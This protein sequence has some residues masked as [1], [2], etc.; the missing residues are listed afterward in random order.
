MTEGLR[1][2]KV[3][4]KCAWVGK[5]DKT[6]VMRV[7]EKVGELIGSG[8]L[9]PLTENIEHILKK[10]MNELEFYVKENKR[11]LRYYEAGKE[12]YQ[13]KAAMEAL[14]EIVKRNEA[15]VLELRALFPKD[16]E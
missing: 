15:I 7:P 2:E 4:I 6:Y 9:V 3:D 8:E 14:M 13:N 1:K 10:R 11:M 16:K 5:S 12:G